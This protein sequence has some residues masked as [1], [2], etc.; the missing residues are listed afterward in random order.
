MILFLLTVLRVNHFIS[1]NWCCDGPP[2]WWKVMQS[3][4]LISETCNKTSNTS[5]HQVIVIMS[6]FTAIKWHLRPERIR[7]MSGILGQKGFELW[8]VCYQLKIA[9]GF[10]SY[11]LKI[12]FGRGICYLLKMAFWVVSRLLKL[13]LWMICHINWR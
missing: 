11:L 4:L 3:F 7:I 10:P 12:A 8:V 5:Y 1:Q 6:L 2:D 9:T 13:A